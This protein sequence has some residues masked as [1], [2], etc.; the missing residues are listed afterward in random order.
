[1]RTSNSSKRFIGKFGSVANRK[2]VWG[3]IFT[4]F[5]FSD[6]TRKDRE[7]EEG[8]ERIRKRTYMDFPPVPLWLVKSPPCNMTIPSIFP[9]SV[10]PF[11][12]HN[13]KKK[14]RRENVQLG[15]ILW[16]PDFAYPKPL[17]PVANSLKF[18]YIH[19]HHYILVRSLT[20]DFALSSP[21][22]VGSRRKGS[23][24]SLGNCRIVLTRY[25]EV[26]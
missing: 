5:F 8:E 14:E 7:E 20:H 4:F 24:G 22:R 18:L 6:A 21:L 15:I 11:P 1:M 12:F 19:Y 17:T 10:F 3:S 13:K 25:L 9:L 16:K 2:N 26:L 23:Y